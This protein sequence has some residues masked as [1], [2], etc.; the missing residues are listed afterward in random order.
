MNEIKVLVDNGI[1]YTCILVGLA[2]MYYPISKAFWKR[3]RVS[4]AHTLPGF[5]GFSV[6]IALKLIPALPFL[7]WVSTKY[8]VRYG[9]ASVTWP[10]SAYVLMVGC[11]L[12]GLVQ[13]ERGR[14]VK[15]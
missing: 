1:I 6:W 8:A 14:L 9:I 11:A 3:Y 2:L 12:Y 13:L 5:K 4:N 10:I 7:M 15:L